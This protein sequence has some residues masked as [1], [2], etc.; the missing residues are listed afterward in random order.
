MLRFSVIYFYKF[1]HI[2]VIHSLSKGIAMFIIMVLG[3]RYRY[4]FTHLVFNG[5]VLLNN[6]LYIL[7]ST[8]PVFQFMLNFIHVEDI[9]CDVL[10]YKDLTYLL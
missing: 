5:P 7:I 4:F 8:S 6:V 9:S 3:N 10:E 1:L 2:V